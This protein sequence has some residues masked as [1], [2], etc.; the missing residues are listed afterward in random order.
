MPKDSDLAARLTGRRFN[1]LTVLSLQAVQY[2]KARRWTY[3][4]TCICDCGRQ[5]DVFA[6]ALLQGRTGSCG[7]DKARYAKMTG[8]LNYHFKGHGEIRAG[9][10]NGYRESAKTRGLLFNLE[11]SWAWAL[12]QQQG[13]CCALTGVPL[14]FGVGRH[15][16]TTA[17]LDRIDNVK[18]Y[19]SGNVQWVHKQVNIMRNTLRVEDFIQW[20]RLVAA[21][22]KSSYTTTPA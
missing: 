10:W 14:T 6:Y 4:A 15:G 13:G 16:N 2:G 20:C 12:Y 9:F 18:G 8:A 19:E 5:K 21:H 7:C 17:S 11:I 1:K 22:A 3:K